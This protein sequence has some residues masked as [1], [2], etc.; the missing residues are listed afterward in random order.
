MSALPLPLSLL[1]LAAL[2]LAAVPPPAPVTGFIDV[3]GGKL[4]YEVRG[5]GSPLVFLHDGLLPAATWDAQFPV[6]ARTFRA[7]RYDRRGYGQSPAPQGNGS[8]S[9]VD[10]LAAVLDSL[11]VDRAILVG[12]S[13]GAQ[14]AV[15]FTL[16]QPDRVEGLVLVGPV[17]SGFPSSEHF[18]RR[19]MVNFRPVFQEKSVEKGIEAWVADPWLTTPGSTAAKARLRELLASNP[20]VVQGLPNP[21]PPERTAAGHLNEI[22]KG[23]L[24]VVGAATSRTFRPRPAPWKPARQSQGAASIRRWSSSIRGRGTARRSWTRRW[25]WRSAGSPA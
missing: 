6:F 23:T 12:C 14:L 15:D 16:V 11:K 18:L 22:R 13:S 25:I 17:M 2:P 4:W 24:L 7:I 9:D 8:W 1:L 20:A 10:D 5:Q 19:R 21:K 3:P